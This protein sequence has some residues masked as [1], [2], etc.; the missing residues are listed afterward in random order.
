ML[1][2]ALGEGLIKSKFSSKRGHICKRKPL[3][4]I[5]CRGAQARAFG[6]CADTCLA[7]CPPSN[8]TNHPDDV[9]PCGR[10]APRARMG[11]ARDVKEG[12]TPC[13][14]T[15][16]TSSSGGNR[17][18][19]TGDEVSLKATMSSRMW[20]MSLLPIGGPTA[21]SVSSCRQR[22]PKWSS[23]AADAALP[24][25]WPEWTQAAQQY[26][27]RYQEQNRSNGAVLSW[28]HPNE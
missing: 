19:S 15:S 24:E 2:P 9:Q 18:G 1:D 28:T 10:H 22:M 7:N 4:T 25:G 14:R 23:V 11:T 12:S 26:E 27:V 6:R 3:Q 21:K 5:E 20:Q 16:P 17:P 13:P 8:P